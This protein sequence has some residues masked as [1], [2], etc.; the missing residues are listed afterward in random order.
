MLKRYIFGCLPII[1]LLNSQGHSHGPPPDSWF[2]VVSFHPT[3]LI[4]G[5]VKSEA[6][7]YSTIRWPLYGYEWDRANEF[8]IINPSY[9]NKKDYTRFGSGLG[10][11]YYVSSDWPLYFQLKPGLHYLK[12]EDASTGPMIEVLGY[13]GISIPATGF[14]DAGVGYKWDCAKKNHGLAVDVNAGLSYV[15]TLLAPF[16]LIVAPFALILE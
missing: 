8:I 14:L 11:R 5:I 3:S 2:D 9:L 10:Y 12:Y 1:F 13:F 4:Y 15:W 7:I 16:I 6:I